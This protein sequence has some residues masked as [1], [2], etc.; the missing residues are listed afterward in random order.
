V[1]PAD[2]A[3]PEIQRHLL[4][5]LIEALAESRVVVLNGARQSGKTTLARQ[6]QAQ[7]GGTFV[8]L[9]DEAI[10]QAALADPAGFVSGFPTP[11]FVD[12][13]QR[14]GD[15]LLR[16]VKAEVDRD[17]RPGR[18]VLTGSTD[19][20]AVPVLSESLAGRVTILDLWPFSQGELLGRVERFIDRV[21][22]EPEALR[23]TPATAMPRPAYFE[24]VVRGGFPEVQARASARGRARWFENYVRTVTE[25]DIRE[26]SRVSRLAELP[27]LV[28]LLAART[29]Q[30]LNVSDLAREI[31]IPQQ[32]LAGYVELLEAVF[33]FQQ[34]PAWSTNLTARVARQPKVFASDAGLASHLLGVDAA[35]LAL[36][37]SALA[38]P[39]LET[40]VVCEL[41]KQRTWSE[42]LVDL[43][44]FRDRHGME[45][46]V[47]L[48][49]RDGRVVGLEVKAAATVTAKDFQWLARMRD[50]LGERFVHGAVLYTGPH[51]A[52]FGDRLSALPVATLWTE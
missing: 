7:R 35:A 51:A 31:R 3:T 22:A 40:F 48:E 5:V 6:L 33:L 8:T 52:P 25:R 36:P 37:T 30:R 44:H 46:D 32:T 10:L 20:L 16:A 12:E 14:G 15:A 17:P 26:L 28:R 29:A 2:V 45:V 38:G 27:A 4:P 24:R 34:L 41:V 23:A 11:L 18:Y 19:F 13:V 43:Y 9:D 39:L 42:T 49:A 47:V 50:A 21:F 1:D